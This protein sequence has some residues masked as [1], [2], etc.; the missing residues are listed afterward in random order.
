MFYLS[1]GRSNRLT[2]IRLTAKEASRTTLKKSIC[3]HLHESQFLRDNHHTL[4][5]KKTCQTYFFT[6]C[7]RGPD[8]PRITFLF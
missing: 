7:N 4:L 2:Q 6:I 1:Y 3:K 8:W 5:K